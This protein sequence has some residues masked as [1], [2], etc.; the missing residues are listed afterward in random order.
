MPNSDID[1]IFLCK[2]KVNLD[3]K[4]IVYLLR[5]PQNKFENIFQSKS[6]QKRHVSNL[7]LEH[8][9]NEWAML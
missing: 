8:D 5:D 3:F 7:N 2:E 1:K 4:Y 6:L 9:Y